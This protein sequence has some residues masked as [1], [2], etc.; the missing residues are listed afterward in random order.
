MYALLSFS[1]RYLLLLRHMCFLFSED[2]SSG[3]SSNIIWSEKLFPMGKV[4]IYGTNYITNI[5]GQT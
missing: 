4:S 1:P 5:Y 2:I 3:F